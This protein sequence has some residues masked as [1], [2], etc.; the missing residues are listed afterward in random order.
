MT[1]KYHNAKLRTR[2]LLQLLSC[3]AV[4]PRSFL[5]AALFPRS[6]STHTPASLYAPFRR[7][8]SLPYASYQDATN[9]QTQ[10]HLRMNLWCPLKMVYPFLESRKALDLLE[11]ARCN[12]SLLHYSGDSAQTCL[13]IQSFPFTFRT[14]CEDDECEDNPANWQQQSMR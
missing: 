14:R 4:S 11:D 7:S 6:R 12:V 10:Q 8:A 9:R 5:P 3:V 13:R 1:E 2:R